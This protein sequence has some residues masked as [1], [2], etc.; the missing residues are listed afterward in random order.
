M[1]GRWHSE[2]LSIRGQRDD[3]APVAAYGVCQPSLSVDLHE[4]C[5]L[6][7][8]PQVRAI[9]SRSACGC[10]LSSTDDPSQR[11]GSRRQR[12][13]RAAAR[14]AA[15]YAC[16][17]HAICSLCATS[18]ILGPH[19]YRCGCGG[20]VDLV[21]PPLAGEPDAAAQGVWRYLSWLPVREPVSLGEP[22][23]PLAALDW[24]DLDVVAKLEGAL[25]TG[26]FK[27]RGAAVL[28]AGLREHGSTGGVVDSSGNA[29]A[30]I[31][32]YCARAGLACEVMAPANASPGKLTQIAAYGARLAAVEGPRSASTDAALA[33]AVEGLSY[34]SHMW[35]PLFLAGTETFAF[36]LA[37]QLDGRMPDWVV[38]PSAAG[39]L[40]LGAERGFRRL[41]TAGRID[42]A[43]RLLAVQSAAA[44]PIVTAWDAG[45][46]LPAVV[47][48]RQG[49][50]EGLL[51][52]RPPRGRQVLA[53]LRATGGAAVA[54]SDDE[55]WAGHRQA[56]RQGIYCEPTS[57]VALGAITMA[58]AR[59]ILTAGDRVVCALTGTGLKSTA[60]IGAAIAG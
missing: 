59:G 51:T 58:R 33:R 26:S 6:D 44:T 35:H 18:V 31:A 50:A 53:A 22:T 57:A 37:E 45:A 4:V 21:E 30:S 25:P 56:A 41:A 54:V 40:L 47:E 32:A 11:G 3:R 2:F 42:R 20:P 14:T 17:V 55:L 19:V 23:T 16:A 5:G 28:V 10:G 34:M 12:R 15:A 13:A 39:T 29:G 8:R 7:G 52:A 27:D 43:P 49:S 36:E 60:A 46:D 48:T 24:G 9:P 38:I 1:Q